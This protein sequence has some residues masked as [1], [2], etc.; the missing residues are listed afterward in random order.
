M[1][2]P[3]AGIAVAALDGVLAPAKAIKLNGTTTSQQVAQQVESE[4]RGQ[5]TVD[6]L[7]PRP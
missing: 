3:V 7:S 5:P 4:T 6:S 2:D 1:S